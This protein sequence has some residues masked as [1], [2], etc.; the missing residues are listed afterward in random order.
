MLKIPRDRCHLLRK[1]SIDAEVPSF[2][3]AWRSPQGALYPSSC[4]QMVLRSA[5][6]F[7]VE[8]VLQL[9][10]PKPHKNLST[11]YPNLRKYPSFGRHV[12]LPTVLA[13]TIIEGIVGVEQLPVPLSMKVSRVPH[14]LGF[15]WTGRYQRRSGFRNDAGHAPRQIPTELDLTK[16]CNKKEE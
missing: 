16:I 8:Q 1:R 11:A 5:R 14:E 13:V 2:V 4:P 6:R 10:L 12:T 3:S 15:Y 7:I 9:R